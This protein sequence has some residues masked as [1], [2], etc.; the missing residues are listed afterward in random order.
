[1]LFANRYLP[2]KVS[3]C[4]KVLKCLKLLRGVWLKRSLFSTLRILV[5]LANFYFVFAICSVYAN[6]PMETAGKRVAEIVYRIDK[7]P[8]TST[9]EELNV[10]RNQTAVQ[11][12]DKL[13]R[14][15]VQQS[16]TALYATQRY[17]QIQVYA[18]EIDDGVVLTYQLTP[19]ARIEEITILGVSDSELRLAIDQVLISKPE[20]TYIPE[21]IK[22]DISRI[23]RVCE[24]YGY[25]DADVIVSDMA[26]R[27]PRTANREPRNVR[28]IYQITLGDPSVINELRIQG[29]AAIPTYRL[30]AACT[31]SQQHPIY[32]KSGVDTDVASMQAMYR[33]NSYPTATIKPTFARETGV[34]Q[35]EVNEGKRVEFKFV[36]DIGEVPLSLQDTFKA[37]IGPLINTSTTAVWERRIKSYFKAAGYHDTT[38]DEEVVDASEIMLTINPGMRYVVSRVRFTGNWAF[39]EME[40]LREM[41]IKPIT[42]FIPNLQA[43]IAKRLFQQ[44]QR[45]FFL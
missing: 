30:E 3:K 34:L 6:V 27:E 36:T 31:F 23:K 26:N 42:G 45:P 38:V 12:G 35:F 14:Y 1:M 20:G 16:I 21:T 33:K 5:T 10:L 25:F 9:S 24:D 19:F 18:Q 39:S 17:A 32:N 11:V 43:R 8:V 2:D 29:N 22:T 41:T 28:L 7:Q 15:A 37:D 13:S 44:E 40:L 4:T